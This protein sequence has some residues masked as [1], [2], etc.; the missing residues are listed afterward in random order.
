MADIL[1]YFSVIKILSIFLGHWTIEHIHKIKREDAC[2]TNF[3]GKGGGGR[4]F[5]GVHHRF[6]SYNTCN[7]LQTAALMCFSNQYS[8]GKF[9]AP[10]LSNIFPFSSFDL[11]GR[12]SKKFANFTEST[13]SLPIYID[14]CLSNNLAYVILRKFNLLVIVLGLEEPP[15]NF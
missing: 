9:S 6:K 15:T 3:R 10:V 4:K 8:S 7:L 13:S 5:I 14:P 2:E 12:K 11:F 1:E